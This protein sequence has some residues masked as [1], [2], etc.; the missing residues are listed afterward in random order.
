M[1]GEITSIAILG[2]RIRAYLKAKTIVFLHE[3]CDLAWPEAPVIDVVLLGGAPS[4]LQQAA[5]FLPKQPIRLWV[6][7]NA[8]RNI[9]INVMGL[10]KTQ[11]SMIPRAKTFPIRLRRSR[12]FPTIEAIAMSTRNG[13]GKNVE[14]AIGVAAELQKLIYEREHRKVQ[15]YWYGSR[16]RPKVIETEL[17]KWSWIEN[18]DPSLCGDV[19]PKWTT[20]FKDPKRTLLLNFSTSYEEDFGVSLAQAEQAGMAIALSRWGAHLDLRSS[21][22]NYIARDSI[23]I[24]SRSREAMQKGARKIAREILD[25]RRWV[26]PQKSKPETPSI[27]EPCLYSDL[28]SI[29]KSQPTELR[30]TLA[31]LFRDKIDARVDRRSKTQIDRWMEN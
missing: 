29:F 31:L 10:S 4:L 19:G 1:V 30:R 14:L 26:K 12:S 24:A 16:L 18:P 27:V 7:S 22:R 28:A 17:K 3:G 11:V 15:F 2:E 6:L 25:R 20:S 9:L 21:R 23:E 8:H 13:R 5:F